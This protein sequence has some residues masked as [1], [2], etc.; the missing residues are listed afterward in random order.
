MIDCFSYLHAARANSIN[1]HSSL[2]P[3][4]LAWWVALYATRP[5][6][7]RLEPLTC[8]SNFH[9]QL[10]KVFAISSILSLRLLYT[11]LTEIFSS[12][13][14]FHHGLSSTQVLRMGILWITSE[15]FT[16]FRA[17]SFHLPPSLQLLN[18]HHFWLDYNLINW[19]LGACLRGTCH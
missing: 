19:C 4:T 15:G 11:C 8:T 1:I 2:P 18:N 7:P 16:V 13:F 5:S 3:P 14:P 10:H 17:S 9:I 6:I 12:S